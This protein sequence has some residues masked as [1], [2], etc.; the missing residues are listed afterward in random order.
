MYELLVEV[1]QPYALLHLLTGLAIL[2]L[3]HRRKESRRRLIL[4]SVAFITLTAVSIPA[5][6]QLAVGTLEWQYKPLNHRP[7]RAGAIVVLACGV[8]PPPPG[9]QRGDL[10]HDTVRRCRHAAT[11]YHQG[12]PCLVVVSGGQ[13]SP[14]SPSPAGAP[15][16]QDLLIELG[17]RPVD[18][19][20]EDR[21]RTTYENAVEC[22]RILQEKGVERPL[23][24]VD[25]VDL[26]RAE[27]CFRKQGVEVIPSA[28]DYWTERFEW[29]LLEFV[30]S[31]NAARACQRVWHEW[32][33]SLWYALRGRI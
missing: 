26:F 9:G 6:A 15:L 20:V 2:R 14:E 12:R 19:I 17:V 23:L 27:R 24:V 13:V 10:D 33:G 18:L 3:W 4:L 5:V 11:L 16:M 1:L 25:A 28:S 8:L 32:L 30:P 22:C 7:E 21:S 29:S 31:P